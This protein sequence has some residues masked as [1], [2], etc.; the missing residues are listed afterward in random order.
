MILTWGA[1]P[2]AEGAVPGWSSTCLVE[3][4]RSTGAL[5]RGTLYSLCPREFWSGTCGWRPTARRRRRGHKRSFG[6]IKFLRARSWFA[7]AK[8]ED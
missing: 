4:L 8:L 5:R 6:I 2:L 3:T 7:N 1:S